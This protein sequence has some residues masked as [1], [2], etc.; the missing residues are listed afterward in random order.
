MKTQ[1][2]LSGIIAACALLGTTA[3]A[4]DLTVKITDI[5]A[6]KGT[7]MVSV[8]NTEAAWNNQEKPVA[9]QKIGATDKEIVLHFKLPAGSYAV[10]VMHDENDN[11]KLD[12]NFM[13]I[14]SEGYGFS[15]N[16]QVMRRANFSES[17]F[18]VTDAPT[19][20]VVRLR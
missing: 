6:T 17:K 9:A 4:G 14:P 3:H 20:I 13:G 10:Q 19:A 8:A 16:P 5:R 2:H 15:N 18:E 12:S 7:L 1:L 11:G